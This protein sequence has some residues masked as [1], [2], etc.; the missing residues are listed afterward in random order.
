MAFVRTNGVLL[1][2]RLHGRDG[3]PAL[4]L[5][6]SLGTD[7]RIW[8]AVIERLS[9]DYR[10][11]SYDKRGH[12]LSGAPP[13]DYRLDDHIGDL[14]ALADAVDARRFVLCGVSVGGVI[15]QGF[16]LRH[17]DR[18]AGLVL[19]D[20]APRIGDDAMW[21]GRIETI[22]TRGIEALADGLMERWFT[23]DYRARYPAEVEG[24]ILQV[25]N[26][27]DVMVAGRPNPITGQ[28]VVA[29]VALREPEDASALG[30]RIRQFC[31]E[32]LAP[33]KVPVAVELVEGQLHGDRF[34]KARAV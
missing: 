24:I 28:V 33:Y 1:H 23:A 22:R 14:A 25:S 4:A 5:V 13:G 18:L 15:A 2:Y 19:S 17:P 30:R 20:T 31:R 10:V 29:R 21:N 32:R 7:A 16:A 3:A 9:A 12:G 34:K 6:N 26:V 8:D 11:I 27:S